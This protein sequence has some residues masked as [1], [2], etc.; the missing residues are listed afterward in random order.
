MK[1]P[2]GL[3]YLVFLHPC[4]AQFHRI[5]HST[6]DSAQVLLNGSPICTTPCLVEYRWSQAVNERLIFTIEKSGF[7]RWS[8]TIRSKPRDFDDQEFVTLGRTIPLYDLGDKSSILGFDKLIVDLMDGTV[9]GS[10]IGADGRSVPIKWEDNVKLGEKRFERRFYDILSKAGIR[11][12]LNPDPKLF[13]NGERPRLPR[14]LV[15]VKLT[16]FRVEL[17][18]KPGKDF[19]DGPVV[20]DTRLAFEWQVLDRSTGKVVMTL[21]T[22]GRSNHRQRT[23]YVQS[24]NISAFEDALLKFLDDGRFLELVRSD[25]A[26]LQVSSAGSALSD[27]ASAAFTV[28]P[29]AMPVFKDLS[30]MIRYADRSCVTIITDGG[31]GSGVIINSDGYVL[32]AQHVIEGTNRVEVQFS[33]GLRQDASILFADIGYDLVLLDIAGSGYRPLAVARNDSTGLGDEVVTIGTPADVALGQ[34][35]SKGILSGKRK[36][37]DHVYLQSDVSVSP[38]NSGGPLLNERG[39]VIG[40]IQSKLVGSGIEGIGFAVPIQ[41][42]MER[43]HIKVIDPQ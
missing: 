15:G 18:H 26:P 27:N 30:D 9:V 29:V 22:T 12:P 7:D 40:I 16:D 20:G 2:L 39:D 8:D 34:S 11:V 28:K 21:S 38:G 19:G 36:I 33:D 13:S 32:S 14:F 17:R 35:V 42:A 25:N 4:S 10:E 37:N 43:L 41:E 31:H 24:D 1:Y 5:F 6:P 23:G 3:F